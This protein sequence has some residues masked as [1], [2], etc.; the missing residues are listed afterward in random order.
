MRK[1][2]ILK[3]KSKRWD[4]LWSAGW[5]ELTALDFASRKWVKACFHEAAVAAAHLLLRPSSCKS[6][7]GN[8]ITFCKRNSSS[9]FWQIHFAIHTIQTT[10]N[11]QL[12]TLQQ[13]LDLYYK[14][15]VGL[16]KSLQSKHSERVKTV[17]W[18]ILACKVS[19]CVVISCFYVCLKGEERS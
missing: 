11:Y 9:R 18:E 19:I 4:V 15:R 10:T 7:A 3:C 14:L 2:T 1:I 8:R 13:V 5:G 6:F 12:H 17:L 16:V